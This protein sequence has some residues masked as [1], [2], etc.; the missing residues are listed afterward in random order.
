L[1]T[2]P[3]ILSL[4]LASMKDSC[5]VTMRELRFLELFVLLV[6]YTLSVFT[7]DA[8]SKERTHTVIAK[9]AVSEIVFVCLS[10]SVILV[11]N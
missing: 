6:A 4:P 2:T 10:T 5:L 9:T 7:N 3:T 11:Y 8:R 1:S